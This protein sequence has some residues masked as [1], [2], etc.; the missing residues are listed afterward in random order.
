[1]DLV[2]FRL[3]VVAS[4]LILSIFFVPFISIHDEIPTAASYTTSIA[5]VMSTS[6]EIVRSD[7]RG[8][9]NVSCPYLTDSSASL[10]ESGVLTLDFTVQNPTDSVIR[11]LIVHFR[12]W[13]STCTS[14]AS[15]YARTFTI[16]RIDPH[17]GERFHTELREGI[18]RF[19]YSL[20]FSYTFEILSYTATISTWVSTT[21][22]STAPT[23]R[24]VTASRLAS[25]DEVMLP[26]SFALRLGVPLTI[27][28][29]V[30]FLSTQPRSHVVRKQ[31][32]RSIRARIKDRPSQNG[33]PAQRALEQTFI[34]YR[35]E[36]QAMVVEGK[37]DEMEYVRLL[38]EFFRRSDSK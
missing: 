1:M 11:N 35:D 27:I 28:A 33:R 25:I 36:L 6:R 3:P 15:D 29:V 21:V 18:F 14:C 32:P 34:K 19:G 7:T 31:P 37:I 24:T 26:D 10:K 23:Q 13:R 17:L 2:R 30:M 38:R 5:S 9:S 8:C 4:L 12:F 16:D 22:V 20:K